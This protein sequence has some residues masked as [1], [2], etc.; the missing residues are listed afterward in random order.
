MYNQGEAALQRAAA[1]D[2]DHGAVVRLLV[3]KGAD[4]TATSDGG[5]TALHEATLS[6]HDTVVRL[7][8][9]K[10]VEKEADVLIR[11]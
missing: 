6:S 8:V 5:E 3:E 7:L 2:A 9:E 11:E 1:A 4:V 10:L